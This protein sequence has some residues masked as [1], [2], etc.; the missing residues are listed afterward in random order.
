[1]IEME[2][3]L[4]TVT[5]KPLLCPHLVR[6]VEDLIDTSTSHVGVLQGPGHLGAINLDHLP[7]TVRQLLLVEGPQ[8]DGHHHVGRLAFGLVCLPLVGL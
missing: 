6:I 4:L 1:M 8:A 3:Q 7:V 5:A 2:A